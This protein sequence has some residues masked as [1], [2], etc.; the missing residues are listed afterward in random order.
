MIL[1]IAMKKIAP[2]RRLCE[3]PPSDSNPLDWYDLP[4]FFA[5]P[6]K[7]LFHIA[8][9]T[10][11]RPGALVAV[12]D[13]LR[14]ES[15]NLLHVS[16]SGIPGGCAVGH[17]YVE[18]NTAGIRAALEERLRESEIIRAVRVEEGRDGLLVG[19]ALPLRSRDSGLRVTALTS[20]YLFSTLDTLREEMG[21]GGAALVYRQGAQLGR[22][23]WA[24]HARVLG[25]IENVRIHLEYLLEG[26]AL[27][28]F[29]RVKLLDI[30]P[31]KGTARIRL[32]ESVECADHQILNPYSQFFRGYFAGAFSTILGGEMTC[33]ETKCIAM[34][35]GTCEFEIARKEEASGDTES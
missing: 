6:G 32:S 29:G 34:G 35:A 33:V 19:K 27:A 4:L 10:E 7:A 9:Q 8:V 12:A 23:A 2:A 5:R 22:E 18:G 3:M 14:S 20:P 30:D 24:R 1:A 25:G 17:L 26:L 16:M 13:I 21:S 15:L 28:G 11:D 31:E